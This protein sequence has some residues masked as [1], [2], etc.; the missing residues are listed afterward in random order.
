[1]NLL[2]N[3]S[4]KTYA[5]TLVCV[6]TGVLLRMA[7]CIKYPVQPRDSFVYESVIAHWEES[8][9]IVDRVTYFPLSLWI[10]KIPHHFFHYDIIKG[11]IVVNVLLGILL[12]I[13]ATSIANYFF[14]NDFVSL[15]AGLAVATHPSLIGFSCTLLRENAYLVF[16]ALTAYVFLR[17]CQRICLLKLLLAGSLG[18][19]AFLC[20]LEGV[21]ILLNIY[22]GIF[23]LLIF[24]RVSLPVSIWHC[25]LVS[26]VFVITVLFVCYCMDFDAVSVY[27]AISKNQLGIVDLT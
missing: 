21:E 18:A 10:L 7:Y 11:G 20:R 3:Q 8:G 24:K 15:I 23:F 5:I 19:L 12:I 25:L 9:R 16:T 1:M 22:I 2:R 13:F 27:R 17:Y 26:L 14:K 6:L 4:V